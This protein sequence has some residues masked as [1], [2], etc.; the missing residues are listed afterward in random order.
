MGLTDNY[1]ASMRGQAQA[2]MVETTLEQNPPPQDQSFLYGAISSTASSLGEL[3]GMKPFDSAVKFREEN[4]WSGLGTELIGGALVP[5]GVMGELATSARGLALTDRAMKAVPGVRSLSAAETPLRYGAARLTTQFAPLELARLGTGF[6]LTEDWNDYGNLLAD[7]GLSTIL[8]GG[9]GAAGGFFKQLGTKEPTVGRAIGA[10]LG[11][12]PTF[13]LRIARGNQAAGKPVS[14]GTMPEEDFINTKMKEVFSS[15]ADDF[16]KQKYVVGLEGGTPEGDAGINALFAPSKGKGSKELLRKPFMDQ[17]G[18]WS[19]PDEELSRISAAAGFKDIGEMAETLVAPRYVEIASERAAGRMGKILDDAEGLQFFGEN[20]WMGREPDSGL[21]VVAKK[22]KAGEITDPLKAAERELIKAAEAL[23]PNVKV[24]GGARVAKGDQWIIGKTDQPQKLFP[25]AHKAAEM[26]VNQ[27]ARWREAFKPSNSPDIFNQRA[28]AM[29]EIVSTKDFMDMPFQT[30]RSMISRLSEKASNHILN[31]TGLKDSEM[32]RRIA[33]QFALAIKPSIFLEGKSP[34]FQRMW[35]HLDLTGR[36]ANETVNRLMGGEIKVGGNPLNKRKNV[37]FGPGLFGGKSLRELWRSLDEDELQLVVRASQTQTPAADLAKLSANGMVSERAMAAITEMQA[38]DR[39]LWEEIVIPAFK[40]GGV[41]T[42]FELLE[43]YIMPRIFKGDWFVPILDEAGNTVW[44]ASGKT[45]QAAKEAAVIVEEA[46]KKGLGWSVGKG[47][48]SH[49]SQKNVDEIGHISELVSHQLA[50]NPDTQEVLE[51][52][53]KR[54]EAARIADKGLKG[55]PKP[56]TPRN[57]SEKRVGISGADDHT[58]TIDEVLKSVEDHYGRILKFAGYHTWRNRWLDEA[59]KLGETYPELADDLRR[60]SNQMMGIE[61]PL[62]QG[63][64]AALS[65]MFGNALGGKAATK[66]ANFTNEAM[67]MWNIGIANPTQAILNLLN[68]IQTVA[69]WIAFMTSGAPTLAKEK[70]MQVGLRW[71]A[72]GR[73]NGTFG[74]MAPMKILYQSMKEMGQPDDLLKHH[75]ARAK[76][77]STLSPQLYEGW[78]GGASRSHQTLREA[79]HDKGGGVAGG[80]EYIKRLSTLMFEK[81]EEFSRVQAFTSAHILGRD[82]FGLTDDALY[83]FARRATH[84]T[85]YGY[86]VVDRSRMFTGPVGSMFG[87][88]KNWQMHFIGGMAQYAGLGVREGIWSPMLWQFGTAM[89]VGGLGATPLKMVADSM[90]KWHDNSNGSFEWLE[91]NWGETA[92]DAVWFGLPSFFGA[93]LQASSAMPGADV[94][95]DMTHLFN[96]VAVDRAKAAWQAVDA[97]WD[98]AGGTDSNALR[99]PNI[100]DQLMQAFL[101]RAMFRAAAATEGDYIKSMKTG[102][103]QIRDVST[104]SQL[105]HAMGVNAVEVERYQKTANDLWKDR[106]RRMQLT[107]TIG[108]GMAQAY[109]AGDREEQ[110]RLAHRALAL[111][112]DLSSVA[113]SMNTR[114]RR[115]MQGDLLSRYGAEGAMARQRLEE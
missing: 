60:K 61:G 27:W 17:N 72:Q 107:A 99:N 104:A 3:F 34:I 40:A 79:Y 50:K 24:Y 46:N 21:W 48:E 58:Y 81:S 55:L 51:S 69:P 62:T 19:F 32:G 115:E 84:V 7:V 41:D 113:T 108:D 80:F 11:L 42:K 35:S 105:V 8:T 65:P 92:G 20:G 57:L 63:L 103:P 29:N 39:Q 77:D 73:V 45:G 22:I 85:M 25:Q 109:L 30:R 1:L 31:K 14:S 67:F 94:R 102:Y 91:N 49:L 88:F 86:R 101:P 18:L 89:A 43:G 93:S 66:I 12:L 10:D 76:T 4:P 78:V 2:K 106:E 70:L 9:F 75:Y 68:P 33:E 47:R 95:N 44:L 37:T 111:G 5:Y 56:G 90:A 16:A 114:L 26:T 83:E 87:L 28:N 110:T 71:D 98:A 15:G 64:N 38:I 59:Y 96:F 36:V 13:E 54:L 97:A 6:A 74:V 82:A 53:M 23:D 52:A 112:L 100:R